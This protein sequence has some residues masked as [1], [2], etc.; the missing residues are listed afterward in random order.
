MSTIVWIL[1]PVSPSPGSSFRI[2]AITSFTTPE[3]VFVSCTAP[4]NSRYFWS[5]SPASIGPSVD[6]SDPANLPK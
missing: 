2:G 6:F 5:G 3:S 1:V 4:P